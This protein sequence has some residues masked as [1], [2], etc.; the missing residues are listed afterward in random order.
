MKIT[1]RK[2]DT[3]LKTHRPTIVC[4]D[5]SSALKGPEFDA[6]IAALQVYV[7]DHVAP[8][9]GVMAKLVKGRDFR[10]GCWAM[11]FLD[12]ADH[13]RS[14]AY[15]HL[16]P[17]GYPQSKVFVETTRAD[18]K[19]VSVAASHELVEMLVDPSMN[20]EVMKPDGKLVHR[21]EVADPVEDLHF[22]INGLPMSDFVYPAYFESFHKP[23]S[24]QFD[25]MDELKRPFQI[26][27]GGYQCVMAKG[28]WT[29]RFGSRAKQKAFEKQDRR[30]RRAAA[31]AATKRRLSAKKNAKRVKAKA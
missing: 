18:G 24:V 19:P 23:G 6:I 27:L 15:H 5:H 3:Y 10:D 17:D 21:Y 31:R 4:I 30:D 7:D 12:H 25:H 11:V 13:A 16:T 1:K 22:K 28:K 9:W 2:I 8:A 14:L 26:H 20:L 29:L